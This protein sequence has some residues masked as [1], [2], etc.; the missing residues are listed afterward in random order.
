MY[1]A[2]AMIAAFATFFAGPAQAQ[3]S[4]SNGSPPPC[5]GGGDDSGI[6]VGDQIGLTQPPVALP[7]PQSGIT[8]NTNPPNTQ[9]P[10][11]EPDADALTSIMDFVTHFYIPPPTGST[12]VEVPIL[13]LESDPDVQEVA[14]DLGSLSIAM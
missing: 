5:S 3:E 14:G 12:T 4:C 11:V 8:S 10:P 9:F 7:L 2:F 1:A 13:D 6:G